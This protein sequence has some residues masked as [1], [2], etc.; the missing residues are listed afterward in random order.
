MPVM[1]EKV[2]ILLGVL[3]LVLCLSPLSP[4]AAQSA[5]D[6]PGARSGNKSGQGGDLAAVSG[7][8]DGGSVVLGS[9]SQIVILFRNDSSK[10]IT[11]GVISLYP[12][13]N[14]SASISKNQCA[15]EALEPDAVCAIAM[16]VK[17]LQPGNYRIEMLMRHDGRSKLITSTVSGKVES[18]GDKEVDLVSDV[19][20]IPSELDFGALTA[21]RPQVRSVIMRNITSNPINVK[22]IYI[23]SNSQSGFALKA[24]CDRLETGQACIAT[25]TWT[26]EQKGPAT[27]V[28]IMEHDGPTGIS[29]I[30]L[31]GSYD[32]G[33]A[34]SA[35][36]FPE[37]VPG[38]GLLVAS[39]TEV[40]FGSG[41]ETSSAITVS[42]VNIGDAPVILNDIRLS[43]DENGVKIS[44]GSCVPGTFLDPVEACPLTLTWEPTR[45]GSILDDIQIS[46]NGARGILVLPLRGSASKAVNKDSKAVI[47]SGGGSSSIDDVMRR[48]P[49]VSVKDLEDGDGDAGGGDI[50]V[51]R[52]AISHRPEIDVRGVLDGFAITSHAPRRAIISGPGGS[53]VLFDGEEAVIGGVLWEVGIRPSSVEF[54]NGDQ[55]VLLLFD[56][57]LSSVNRVAGQS[58]S[59]SS[60]ENSGD[61][62]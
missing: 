17:G 58:D 23:E 33:T 60:S 13:S 20:M 41:I 18:T 57:S 54:T 7:K 34:A 43:N 28:L 49:P 61:D 10:P 3:C 32:P 9:S 19:E 47:V 45:E 26:P 37:A 51:P 50:P 29:S 39:Q 16:S 12:S 22:D 27:G 8:I 56:K 14:V 46:H 59:G 2:R 52:P 30:L 24:D 1:I 21:S 53:R 48:I 6:D 25:I 38:K 15:Q 55:K 35:E 31:D 44:G 4:A 36:V 42:L 62:N 11:T 40:D 5:F